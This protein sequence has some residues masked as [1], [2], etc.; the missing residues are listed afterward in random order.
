M[1]IMNSRQDADRAFAYQDPLPPDSEALLD[2][3]RRRYR[4]RHA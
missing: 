3:L 4:A 1:A 2:E